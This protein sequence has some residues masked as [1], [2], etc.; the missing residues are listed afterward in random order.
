MF[1]LETES[2]LRSWREFRASLS[3]MPL[4]QALDAVREF[5][6]TVPFAPYYLDPAKPET[7]PTP[8][9][10]IAENYYCDVA[11]ALGMLY[12]VKFSGH[13]PE[14]EAEILNCEESGTGF[15]YNLVC[16]A[17]GKYVLNYADDAVV[18]ITSIPRELHVRCRWTTEHLK[19]SEY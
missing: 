18:Y 1:Q 8:W 14:L 12:T 13:G 9:E 11:K 5:W 6:S 17:Q 15:A 16:L 10:L 4:E 7:W 19:L 2:R 3:L